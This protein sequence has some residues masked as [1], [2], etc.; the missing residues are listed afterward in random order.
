MR[1]RILLTLCALFSLLVATAQ[2]NQ[3]KAYAIT[4]EKQG[5]FVWTEVKLIDL[6]TGQVLQ[7]VFENNRSAYQVY[8]ARTGNGIQVKDEKGMITNKQKQPFSTFSA[9]CAYDKKHN[10]LYYTPMFINEL[11]YIDLSAKAPKLYY[12]EG[13]TLSNAKDLN[14]EANHITRMVIASDGNGYA[15][16]NDGNHFVKFTT[17]RK[18]QITDLGTLQDDPKNGRIS[19]HNRCT[20]WGGDMVADASGNIYMMSASRSIF[21]IDVRN[22]IATYI[23]AISGLPDKFTTNGA[24]IDN[25]GNLI[26]SSA[27]ST[28][29]YYRVNMNDWTSIKINSGSQVFNASDLANGNFAFETKLERIPLIERRTGTESK[30]SVYPNPVSEGAFR[31]SFDSKEIGRYDIQLVDLLGRRI[32]TKTVNIGNEGQVVE[33]PVSEKLSKG[34]YMVK[35]LNNSKRTVHAEKIIIE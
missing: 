10:R 3:N 9:A 15:L 7:S 6:N 24:V 27:N 2:K 32:A 34:L 4:S 14:D 28:D 23:G 22:R 26:V 19:V 12:F 1:Y 29:G 25:E 16:S 35:V 33:F 21:K 13:E 5:Q 8:N 30:I 18:P 11:R 17:G 31:V 20:S